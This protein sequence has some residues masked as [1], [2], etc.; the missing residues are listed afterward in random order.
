[1][2]HNIALKVLLKMLSWYMTAKQEKPFF[3]ETEL[4]KG[5]KQRQKSEFMW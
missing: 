4:F 2:L 1:M 3:L 5:L